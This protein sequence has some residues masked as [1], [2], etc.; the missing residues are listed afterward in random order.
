MTECDL[1]SR[2][3]QLTELS[4]IALHSAWRKLIVA[5]MTVKVPYF[6]NSVVYMSFS[7]LVS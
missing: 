3:I 2:N 6:H 5:L 4:V 1:Q 7:F